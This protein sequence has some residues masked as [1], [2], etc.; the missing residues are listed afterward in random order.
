M[1]NTLVALEDGELS[2][3]RGGWGHGRGHGFD[4][5]GFGGSGF[6]FHRFGFHRFGFGFGGAETDFDIRPVV[7]VDDDEGNCNCGL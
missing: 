5:G 1:N 7:V 6:G 2:A 3:V 4:C